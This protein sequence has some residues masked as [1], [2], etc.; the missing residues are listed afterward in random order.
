MSVI[1]LAEFQKRTHRKLYAGIA[2]VI[3]DT[4]PIYTL[5]PWISYAGEGMIVN[6]EK[7]MGDS[8]FYGL[9][10]TITAKAP[11]S[12]EPKTFTATRIIGDAEIDGKQMVE[13]QSSE[14]DLV[15]MEIASKSK[16][17]G[18]K[19]K[20]GMV[21]GT[22][23]LPEMNS[24]H[25]LTD[26]GQYVASTG[27][28]FDDCDL[29]TQKVLSK[30]GFVDFL[31]VP[32]F[33]AFK[34]R[35]AYRALG[36]VP[37]I[38]VKSGNRSFKIMEFNG[39]PVFTNSFLPATES[40]DGSA[41]TGGTA[42]SIYAGNFDDGTRKVGAAFIYP[43]NRPMGLTVQHIGTKQDKD[44]DAWRIKSYVELALFNPNGVARV[45]GCAT[46]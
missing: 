17:V 9:D 13:S 33:Q 18:R 36:G 10:D 25:T 41:L 46:S 45:T 11:S 44:Q 7:A 30:D 23:V 8:A 39:I 29:A 22:G 42:S 15:T 1:T 32:S 6:R 34:M 3:L 37:M 24:F 40:A 5:F 14:N 38:E 2:E 16:S 12:V 31:M 4:D 35:Q 26:P 28:V 27:N 21:T 20:A 43:E 19:I